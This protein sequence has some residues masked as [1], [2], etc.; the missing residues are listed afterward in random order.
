M[1]RE[2][3]DQGRPVQDLEPEA[4]FC[5]A[6]IR[7]WVAARRPDG[8]PSLDWREVCRRGELSEDTVQAFDAFL[9]TVH[10]A[11]RRPL[12]IR[13]C[14][15]PQVG[16]DEDLLLA[17]IAALQRDDALSALDV[18]ASWLE[19]PAIMPALPLAMRLAATARTCGICLRGH[20]V[21]QP[22]FAT[23]NLPAEKRI[24]H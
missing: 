16:R 17:L 19:Q 21:T 24:M 7:T 8:M 11:M 10:R 23:D 13:C 4:L 22:Q 5:I 9:H 2:E 14:T 1:H 3:V 15:C 12:D 20:T 6:V 18:L